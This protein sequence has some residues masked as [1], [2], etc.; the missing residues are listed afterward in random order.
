MSIHQRTWL[1]EIL[2]TDIVSKLLETRFFRF[3]VVGT[4]GFSVDAI[5]LLALDALGGGPYF[6]RAVSFPTA[7]LVTW[8]L[9]RSWTFSGH[10]SDDRT[11]E[12]ARYVTVNCLAAVAN[13][14][15]YTIAIETVPL[16]RNYLIIPLGLGAI[17]GLFVNYTGMKLFVFAQHRSEI[18]TTGKPGMAQSRQEEL[19]PHE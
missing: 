14:G 10:Q 7:M 8:L 13:I 11:K 9:N 4:I 16:L 18:R 5:L 19:A 1:R 3:L 12:L 15:A 6:S 2:E 17:A